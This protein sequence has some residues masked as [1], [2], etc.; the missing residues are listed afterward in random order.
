M[1]ADIHLIPGADLNPTPRVK[2]TDSIKLLFIS[3]QVLKSIDNTIVDI[4]NKFIFIVIFFNV[5]GMIIYSLLN[6]CYY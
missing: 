4:F 2:L 3:T 6:S 1:Q 5:S